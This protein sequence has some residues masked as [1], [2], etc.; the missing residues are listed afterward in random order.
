MKN[1]ITINSKSITEQLIEAEQ[2]AK[3]ESDARHNRALALYGIIKKSD[4]L[5]RI[6]NIN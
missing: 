1:L 6:T 2:Q 4:L 3:A 5:R